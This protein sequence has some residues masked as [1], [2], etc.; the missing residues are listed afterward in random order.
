M[1]RS[2]ISIVAALTMV[3]S[4]VPCGAA[5]GESAGKDAAVALYREGRID[6]AAA[7]FEKLR[8]ESPG[9]D[10]LKTWH[11]L[12][13]LEKARLM[14][15]AGAGNARDIVNDAWAVLKAIRGR[16]ADN[17]T[18]YLAVAKA[19]WLNDRAGKA[20]K[21]LEKAFFYKADFPEGQLLLGDIALDEGRKAPASSMPDPLRSP[22]QGTRD[23]LAREAR[24][25]FGA[26]LESKVAAAN[27]RA[28]AHYKLGM[29]AMD[30]AGDRKAAADAWEAAVKADPG[31]RHGKLAAEKLAKDAGR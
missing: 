7:A 6:E 2:V 26:V 30:L 23:D 4:A 8:A 9:D 1:R 27:A 12:A 15:E 3:A 16:N 31:S 14:K 17:P 21:S 22:G 18:W 10:D 24:R 11:A 29:T 5:G 13:R 19:L 28:E 25:A 20:R